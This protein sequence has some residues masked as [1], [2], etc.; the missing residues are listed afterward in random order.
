MTAPAPDQPK[1][2]QIVLESEEGVTVI[3]EGPG[4]TTPKPRPPHIPPYSPRAIPPGLLRDYLAQRAKE[5]PEQPPPPE[6]GGNDELPKG[7]ANNR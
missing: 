5:K 3:F 7:D 2:R 6:K 1:K 4:A